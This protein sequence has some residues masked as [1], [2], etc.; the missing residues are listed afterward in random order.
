M[1]ERQDQSIREQG[2]RRITAVS[3]G[4]LAAGVTGTV[5][6]AGYTAWAQSDAGQSPDRSS[7]A[8][9]PDDR[10]LGRAPDDQGDDQGDDRGD[11]R[12]G[13]AQGTPP[14][15]QQGT[16]QGTQ[17]GGQQGQFPQLGGSAGPGQAGSAGS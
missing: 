16:Q 12:G 13:F 5:A 4:L 11:D 1:A 14:Q 8:G 2:R 17:Q 6:L 7:T 9:A 10:G 15:N 3:A